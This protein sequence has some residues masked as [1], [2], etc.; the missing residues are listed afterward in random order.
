MNKSVSAVG[1]KL[2]YLVP[3]CS[4][5]IGV[6]VPVSR[7]TTDVAIRASH[8]SKQASCEGF[9]GDPPGP[10]VSSQ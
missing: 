5:Y 9:L 10:R 3:I 2:S 4:L 6:L 1:F 8:N 7:L